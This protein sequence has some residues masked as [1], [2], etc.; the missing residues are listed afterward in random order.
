MLPKFKKGDK[1]RFTKR[2]TKYITSELAR[3]RTRTITAVSYN[4]EDQ[5]SYY[6]LNGQGK[7]ELGWFRSYELVAVT[8]KQSHTRGKPRKILLAPQ[9]KQ[10]VV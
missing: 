6:K 2:A 4:D 7:A 10:G 5:C 3:K 9:D 1:V 8:E